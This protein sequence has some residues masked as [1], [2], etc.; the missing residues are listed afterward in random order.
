MA[1]VFGLSTSYAQQ[2]EECMNNLSMFSSYAQN[3]KYDDAYGPWMKVRTK[4]PG[5]NQSVY[6]KTRGKG[7]QDILLYKIENSTGEE[8]LAF[9]KDLLK[10]YDE[11]NQYFASKF[12]MGEMLEDKGNLTYDYRKE[13]GA[14][15]EEI[16][17][18]YDEAYTK[19]L[20][21]FTSPKGLYV[22]FKMM[23]DL[24]DAGERTSQQL[25]DKYDDVNDKIETEVAK[26]STALNV[27][28]EKEQAGTELTKREG[29]Y[30]AQYESYL[31]V[32][33]QISGSVDSELG[34]RATCEVL[35][36]L[37]QKDYEANKNDAK[38]L[39]R[40]MD[41]MYAKEC[42]DDPM[43][44][45][46]VE[47]KNAI[48]PDANTA[49]YLGKLYEDEG[50]LSEAEKYYA[51]SMNLQT[52]PLKKWSL[53]YRMAERNRKKG[54]YGKARQ[55]YRDALKLNP[56]NGNPYIKIA[57]MYASSA[58]S[59]GDT[60]FNKQ[61]VFWLAAD[62]VR[63]AGRIDGR[64]RSIAEQYAANYEAKAPSK[65]QIFTE[66]NSGAT[67]NIGCWIGASVKVP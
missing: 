21:N 9:I 7:G 26:S 41:K 19:D 31:S 53:V 49:Y 5:F 33:D 4:C 60:Q 12:P 32:Y 34:T 56:S 51:Q 2:D 35:I 28:L 27:L 54:A 66:N 25:F 64:L 36:P 37:Y 24:Y 67:I 47:Q 44:K 38:W 40:A 29:Q 17:K 55:L 57:N 3:K 14:T 65:S 20:E 8:Q 6:A 15:S 63:K 61:A 10:L 42:S 16:Y 22:Y 39:Q 45:T 18:I 11:Y 58:N 62:E 52:D 23:V 59:C 46:L 30:K 1:L 48:Q 43:F 50:K 13:L